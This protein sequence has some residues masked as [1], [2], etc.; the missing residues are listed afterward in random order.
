MI[1]IDKRIWI[2]KRELEFK[3]GT[4]SG[5]GGQ[6]V[7]KVETKVT[8]LFHVQSSSVFSIQE[9][10]RLHARLSTR[11]NKN[12][13]LRVSSSKFRSQQ[14]NREAVIKRFCELV[15]EAIKPV[16][17]RKQSRVSKNQKLQRLNEK[18][19]RS[20]QKRLRAKMQPDDG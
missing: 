1:E 16:K 2:P 4:S 7:N 8:L 10:E 5:P 11:I 12:G 14:G 20:Q 15:R 3:F 13:F 6:H 18:K 19:K 9:K 17:K